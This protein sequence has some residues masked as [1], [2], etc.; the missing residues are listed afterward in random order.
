MR[1]GKLFY[2][3]LGEKWGKTLDSFTHTGERTTDRA[4]NK[5][6]TEQSKVQGHSVEEAGRDSSMGRR[7][8]QR[9]AATPGGR[10]G[11]HS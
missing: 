11:I 2:T 9:G 6:R 7:C 10:G 1:S 4:Q 3:P 5:G 8:R